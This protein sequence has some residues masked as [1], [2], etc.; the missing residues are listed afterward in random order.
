MVYSKS[1]DNSIE[2]DS[3][4]Q[5]SIMKFQKSN[6]NF[7]KGGI[8]HIDSTIGTKKIGTPNYKIRSNLEIKA[9]RTPFTK[10]TSANLSEEQ[11]RENILLS[12]CHNEKHKLQ[13]LKSNLAND[14]KLQGDVDEAKEDLNDCVNVFFD[15]YKHPDKRVTRV[16]SGNILPNNYPIKDEEV[17]GPN[18]DSC[19]DSQKYHSPYELKRPNKVINNKPVYGT[20]R[21]IDYIG[22]RIFNNENIN[23]QTPFDTLNSGYNIKS[24]DN[25]IYNTTIIENYQDKEEEVANII[26]DNEIE[27]PKPKNFCENNKCSSSNYNYQNHSEIYKGSC[28]TKSNFGTIVDKLDQ[29]PH[30][31]EFVKNN[32]IGNNFDNMNRTSLYGRNKATFDNPDLV[33]SD[34]N[35]N[36]VRK[37][38]HKNFIMN[39]NKLRDEFTFDYFKQS[40]HKMQNN[41]KYRG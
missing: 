21:G 36:D 17:F 40:T 9:I 37:G 4:K 13:K 14:P 31:S 35:L 2:F 38:S 15:H 19:L 39:T 22:P 27:D 8:I 34:L 3:Y 24:T 6:Q 16:P 23:R 41:L 33:N 11:I 20:N 25:M 26:V 29:R 7:E 32:I 10:S 12:S 1:Y 28:G 5:K 18:L 30:I